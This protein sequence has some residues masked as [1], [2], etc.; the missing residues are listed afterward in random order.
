MTTESIAIIGFITTVVAGFG[1]AALG[2]FFANKTATGP[3]KRQ[4]FAKSSASFRCAFTK[5]IRL[6]SIIHPGHS[7]EFQKTYDMLKT[8]YI[9]H[10]NATI[11]FE[12]YLSVPC[13]TSFKTKWKEYCCYDEKSKQAEFSDYKTGGSHTDEL[14]VRNLAVLR[15]EALLKFA[16]PLK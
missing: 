13:L 10:Q 14:R 5:E 12:P 1:G 15:I 16:D 7:G 4:E 2:S 3:M 11:R 6:L 8:A 9:K